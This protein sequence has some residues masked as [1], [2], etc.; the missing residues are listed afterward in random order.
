MADRRHH[1]VINLSEVPLSEHRRGERYE[2]RFG[3]LAREVGAR[4]LGYRLVVVPPGK[5]AWPRHAHH[6]NEELFVVLSGSG[7]AVIGEDRV[8]IR[9]GD[10]VAAPPEPG[11]PHQIVNDSAS[12][13]RYLAVSTME[14]PDVMTY[15]DSGKV[16]VLAGA[17]PGGDK[18]KR[19]M[20]WFGHL[21]AGV[22][23][24][25]GED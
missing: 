15:P 7:T 11:E 9:E 4:K 8:P 19:T 20:N 21:D 13:L 24:W 10:V 23:Y 1:R 18:N 5:R 6:A 16:G 22:D 12:E 3:A 14:E 25:E 17:A 2:A